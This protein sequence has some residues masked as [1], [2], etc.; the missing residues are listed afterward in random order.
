MH[1]LQ[2]NGYDSKENP[3][4]KLTGRGHIYYILAEA[5]ESIWLISF[6]R[7]L[8]R[9]VAACQQLA[10]MIS[11]FIN[12]PGLDPGTNSEWKSEDLLVGKAL[13]PPW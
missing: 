7:D 11:F 1:N 5:R 6:S 8:F 4:S 12:S 13:S 2:Q 3:G 10:E 9:R